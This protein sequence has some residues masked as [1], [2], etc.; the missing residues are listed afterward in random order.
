ME[1]A[2]VGCLRPFLH[3]RLQEGAAGDSLRA[4]A[5]TCSVRAAAHLGSGGE[6]SADLGER[7]GETAVH[8]A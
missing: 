1:H 5:T 4:R 2:G 3:I 8:G 7:D 6:V